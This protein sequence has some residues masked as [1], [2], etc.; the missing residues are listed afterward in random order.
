VKNGWS[1]YRCR[2]WDEDYAI[3]RLSKDAPT[4]FWPISPFD[5]RRLVGKGAYLAG[6]PTRADDPDAQFMYQSRGA[7]LGTVRVDS[8]TEQNSKGRLRSAIDDTTCLVAHGLDTAKI[9]S[10]GP[11]WSFVD[12][13]AD[14]VGTPWGDIDGGARKK[15]VLLNKNV[16]AQIA[17]WVSRGLTAR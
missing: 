5:P 3:I 4:P 8:C 14:P 17:A 2:S 7:I 11:L 13:S 6:Y 10:G 1:P 15:A 12:K 16:R 9:M